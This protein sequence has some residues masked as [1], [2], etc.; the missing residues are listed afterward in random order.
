SRLLVPWLLALP[1][2]P[3]SRTTDCTVCVLP[4]L[5]GSEYT[6]LHRD[7]LSMRPL[8]SHRR[9][10][11]T[12]IPEV[13]Q[14]RGRPDRVLALMPQK[15]ARHAHDQSNLPPRAREQLLSTPLAWPRTRS[16]YRRPLRCPGLWRLA[17]PRRQRETPSKSGGCPE[18]NLALPSSRNIA[19]RHGLDC[20]SPTVR[21]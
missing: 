10:R 15:R 16:L 7:G 8:E 5:L 4:H 14:D 12:R 3:V 9:V 18:T 21:S 1:V 11:W 17:D 13:R 19:R 2:S 20:S 6:Q